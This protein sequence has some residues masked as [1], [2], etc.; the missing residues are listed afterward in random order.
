MG[1]HVG[2][3]A[4]YKKAIV[5]IATDASQIK[6]HPETKRKISDYKTSIEF[7]EGMR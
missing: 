3:R 6:L 2:K 7:F 1:V 4:G 5:T